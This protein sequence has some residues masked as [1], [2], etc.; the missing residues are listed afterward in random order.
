[1]HFLRKRLHADFVGLHASLHL[2]LRLVFSILVIRSDGMKDN[3]LLKNAE[4]LAVDIEY[5]C[6]NLEHKGNSNIIF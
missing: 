6:K 5:L 4:Q 1:M 3:P 2:D